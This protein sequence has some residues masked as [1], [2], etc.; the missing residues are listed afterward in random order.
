MYIK[1]D[2][3]GGEGQG[4]RNS[5]QDTERERDRAS[6]LVADSWPSGGGGRIERRQCSASLVLLLTNRRGG[7]RLGSRHNLSCCVYA[8]TMGMDSPKAKHFHMDQR[9]TKDKKFRI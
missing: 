5:R 6:K 7:G 1:G 4:L 9:L 2:E 3:E 8:V